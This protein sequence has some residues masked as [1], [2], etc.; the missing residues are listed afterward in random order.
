MSELP[1]C[2]LGQ[3]LRCKFNVTMSSWRHTQNLKWC[4]KNNIKINGENT[5]FC[6]EKL[7]N[8]LLLIR[9]KTKFGQTGSRKKFYNKEKP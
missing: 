9:S 1:D 6:V 7:I 4:V 3:K 8:C 2:F 5:M